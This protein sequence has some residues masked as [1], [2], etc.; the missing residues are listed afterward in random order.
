[1]SS[2]PPA[3][4]SMSMRRLPA[5]T[6]FSSSSLTTEAG[7]SI[8]SPAAILVT[9]SGGSWWMR[10]MGLV[11][12]P[13]APHGSPVAPCNAASGGGFRRLRRCRAGIGRSER[14]AGVARQHDPADQL[15]R[16]AALADELVVELLQVEVL[17][18]ELP[19]VLAEL[20]DLELAQG[21]VQVRRV[22]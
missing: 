5:S 6:E 21:V 16:D 22:V 4:R 11:S 3:S 9:T 19:V 20:E 12:P 17:A 8:T 7:R 14:R 1:I 2:V 13:G 15:D 10:G 18:L